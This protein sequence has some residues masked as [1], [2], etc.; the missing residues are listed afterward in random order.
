M[1]LKLLEDVVLILF[2]V[3]LV[4][5]TMFLLLFVTMVLL[6]FVMV[7]LLFVTMVLLFNF[8]EMVLLL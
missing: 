1:V 4:C 6:L 3:S 8:Q 7:F 5:N 2:A